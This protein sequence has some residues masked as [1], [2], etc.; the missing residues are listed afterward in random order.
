MCPGIPI[1][2]EGCLETFPEVRQC[3]A[4]VRGPRSLVQHREPLGMPRR[5]V[6]SWRKLS[7]GWGRAMRDGLRASSLLSLTPSLRE[8]LQGG[9]FPS[10]SGDWGAKGNVPQRGFEGRA[11]PSPHTSHRCEVSGALGSVGGERADGGEDDE[12][13][14]EEQDLV[15]MWVG[16]PHPSP[17]PEHA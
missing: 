6:E 10:P 9:P 13:E 8:H 14:G 17:T 7:T 5:C 4:R 15:E 3:W 16:S 11:N 12:G 2:Q 1:P